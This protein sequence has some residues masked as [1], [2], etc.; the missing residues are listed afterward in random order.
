MGALLWPA[1]QLMDI[2]GALIR[3]FTVG[4]AIA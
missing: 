2:T 4:G 1:F 3:G